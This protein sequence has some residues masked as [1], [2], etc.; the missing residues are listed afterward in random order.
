MACPTVWLDSLAAQMLNYRTLYRQRWAASQH[1]HAP[2]NLLLLL[3]PY[4]TAG[5]AC[6]VL[7]FTGCCVA[8][9]TTTLHGSAWGSF[10]PVVRIHEL[11]TWLCLAP[12]RSRCIITT[13]LYQ[14]IGCENWDI[15]ILIIIPC[16]SIITT[17]CMC[18]VGVKRYHACVGENRPAAKMGLLHC[19]QPCGGTVQACCCRYCSSTFSS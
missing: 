6:V 1:W 2:Q 19:H 7:D 9:P 8:M 3:L 15:K 10:L 17:T 4:T 12:V 5:V 11:C 13:V 18:S 14:E 16:C